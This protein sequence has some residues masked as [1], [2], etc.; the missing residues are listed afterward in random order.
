MFAFHKRREIS[1]LAEEQLTSQDGLC[2][3]RVASCKNCFGYGKLH[4]FIRQKEGVAFLGAFSKLR[5]ATISFVMSVRPHGITGPIFVKCDMSI[6]RKSV[7]KVKVSLKSD[8]T[9]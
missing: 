9:N 3:M 7:E 5:K 6:F 2:D 4:Y 1:R 8:K